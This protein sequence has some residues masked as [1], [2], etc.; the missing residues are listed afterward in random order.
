MN[1]SQESGKRERAPAKGV[2]DS[3]N[4]T[5]FWDSTRG[6]GYKDTLGSG[7]GEREPAPVR[8][9]KASDVPTQFLDSTR[10]GGNKGAL[11]SGEGECERAPAQEAKNSDDPSAFSYWDLM[12]TSETSAGRRGRAPVEGVMDSDIPTQSIEKKS[13]LGDLH[14]AFAKDKEVVEEHAQWRRP[15]MEAKIGAETPTDPGASG[16]VDGGRPAL[17]AR[18]AEKC[19]RI[20]RQDMVES[21]ERRFS[22]LVH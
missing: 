5:R 7:K 2:K 20:S 22:D 10:A 4:P 21:V 13:R 15:E 18:V 12:E 6:G 1:A 9:A 11:G 8:A 3:D 19:N 16:K 17:S 14:L